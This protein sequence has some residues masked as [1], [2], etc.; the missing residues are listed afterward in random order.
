MELEGFYFI[1]DSYLSRA[2][3]ISDVKNALKAKVKIV[4]YREKYASS[5]Q[6]Y[7][8]ALTLRRI[9]KEIIFLIND[10]IDVA[11]AV[12]ADGVHLGQDDLPI[13]VARKLLGK[14][15]IIGVSVHNLK[16]A[17][18]AE[19]LGADYISV[20]PIF[21]TQTKPDIKKPVGLELIREIKKQVSLPLV[22]IGGINL[23][24]AKEVI[25]SGAD[26]ICAISSVVTKKDVKEQIERFQA[27][28]KRRYY[29]IK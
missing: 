19:R 2:G 14:D 18:Q 23:F 21:F 12:D 26:S 13:Q 20:G 11:L 16:Q 17:K 7:K 4:Q 9:C 24:N 27:L 6:M 22:A 28:F 3:N 1:T 10:R 25:A 8:E 15:K 5:F 29:G